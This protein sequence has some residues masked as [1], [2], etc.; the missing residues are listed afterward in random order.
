VFSPYY[1][2]SGRGRPEN[3]CA[4]NVAL[5][6]RGGHRWAM[7]ERGE[8]A[9]A[10]GSSAFLVGPSAM[11]WE[12]DRL[13][14]HINEVTVPF[15]SRIR[16][17]VRLIPEA[18]TERRFMLDPNERHRWWPVAPCSRIEVDLERPDLRWSGSGYFDNNDGDEPLE[19]GFTH[20]DW[21]RASLD[22]GKSAA[23]LYDVID[24]KGQHSNLALRADP[25]GR[26]SEV[27][28]PSPVRLPRTLWRMPRATRAEG[29]ASVK[30]TLEDAP[31]Y[32]R[33]LLS[34]KLMGQEALAM[35][36]SLSL[37]RFR[38]GIVKAMLPFR[39][40]RRV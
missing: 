27:E 13:V 32:A 22:N 25:S 21:A 12:G 19:D 33:S 5:Y 11:C 40:P 35:H 17:T 16:G 18:V 20:W 6:G 29:G 10:R 36:E 7:T 24:R 2:W 38:T 39:M 9:V 37:D 15:P 1:A 26:V 34:T 31:F 4:L 8:K 23:L 3:H 28:P 14:F 30:A